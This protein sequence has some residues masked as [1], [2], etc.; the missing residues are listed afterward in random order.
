MNVANELLLVLTLEQKETDGK[1]QTK[2]RQYSESAVSPMKE[3]NRATPESGRPW[4]GNALG[5]M[6]EDIFSGKET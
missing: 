2:F 4:G 5:S 3:I 1:G 6:H